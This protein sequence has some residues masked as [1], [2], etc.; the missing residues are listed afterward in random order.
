M[1]EQGIPGVLWRFKTEL[2]LVAVLAFA[3]GVTKENKALK[4]VITTRPT[5]EEKIVTRVEKGP[6]RIVE[7]IVVKPGGERIVD[8]VVT[9]EIVRIEREAAKEEAP[10]CLPERKRGD[11]K[12]LLGMG[13]NPARAQDGQMLHL[14]IGVRDML[15]LSYGHSLPNQPERHDIRIV[16]RW[17]R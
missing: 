13:A 3:L 4:A 7:R 11:Y 10:A 16:T 6:V 5:V 12:F 8:R 1:I 17:G 9:R 15:D 14:G 2:A